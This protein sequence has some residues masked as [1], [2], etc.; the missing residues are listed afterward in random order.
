LNLAAKI[1]KTKEYFFDDVHFT[2]KGNDLV[3]KILADHFIKER[4]MKNL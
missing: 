4:K 2:E 3:A 1:P